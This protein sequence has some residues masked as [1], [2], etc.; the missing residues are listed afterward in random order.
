MYII[1]FKVDRE[2]KS[3]VKSDKQE[4]TAEALK[5]E[6]PQRTPDKSI[7]QSVVPT[8]EGETVQTQEPEQLPPAVTPEA[9]VTQSKQNNETQ[10]H[11]TDTDKKD[12]SKYVK[13]KDMPG[14]NN[15]RI[16]ET[17]Q[18]EFPTVHN[19]IQSADSNA[20][21]EISKAMISFQK[22]LDAKDKLNENIQSQR[23][24]IE[25][26]SRN[27]HD[28][29]VKENLDSLESLHTELSAEYNTAKYYA[30]SDLRE[31]GETDRGTATDY[32]NQLS[33]TDQKVSD[34]LRTLDS[35]KSVS[36]R[37]DTLESNKSKISKLNSE[38]E[39][40][41]SKLSH[42]RREDLDKQAELENKY[43]ESLSSL[44]A[45]TKKM[46]YQLIETHHDHMAARLA[47]HTGDLNKQ[48]ERILE[49]W[50]EAESGKYQNEKSEILSRFKGISLGIDRSAGFVSEMKRFH[51]VLSLVH[52]LR[53]FIE[54]REHSAPKKI[55]IKQRIDTLCE[56][57]HEQPELVS[58]LRQIPSVVLVHGLVSKPWILER[59][60]RIE[61][62]CWRLAYVDNEEKLFSYVKSYFRSLIAFSGISALNIPDLEQLEHSNATLLRY[63]HTCIEKGDLHTAARLMNNLNGVAR[64]EASHWV[65]DAVSY[66][67][68]EQVVR[69]L[70]WFLTARIVGDAK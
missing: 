26:V 62:S 21:R 68:T 48:W 54:K 19:N 45:E 34:A 60:R 63:A 44:E 51:L 40:L 29:V 7:D 41:Q 69:V 67:E 70:Y 36:H 28:T 13:Q 3:S 5:K 56:H 2:E 31:L 23:M 27:P 16:E 22:Y 39:T 55:F 66:L 50:T 12:V 46:M 32:E 58:L 35:V 15:S 6:E 9:E 14:Y 53:E 11:V 4:L 30:L 38:I 33:T 47:E 20:K 43:N 8:S 57:L 59:F 64:S 42:L 18:D 24:E 1:L 52:E 65:R 10:P 61:R 49:E 17:L 25:R 37:Q